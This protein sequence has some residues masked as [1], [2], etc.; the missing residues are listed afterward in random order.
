[1][2]VGQEERMRDDA[3]AAITY[4][5]ASSNLTLVCTTLRLF[6]QDGHLDLVP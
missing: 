5:S 4:I 6:V 2:R 3:M 1:M